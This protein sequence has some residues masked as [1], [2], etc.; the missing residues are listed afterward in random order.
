M[1]RSELSVSEQDRRT[2]DELRAQ[3]LHRAREFNRV[4]ILAALDRKSPEPVIMHVLNVGRTAIWRARAAYLQGGL[5]FVLHDA[6]RPGKP[7]R[8]ETDAEAPITTLGSSPPPPPP[9]AQRRTVELP[10]EAVRHCR[11]EEWGDVRAD[12]SLDELECGIEKLADHPGNG[13]KRE[14]VRDGYRVLSVGSHAVYHAV[15][16]DVVHIISLLNGR[17]DPERPLE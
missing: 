11:C 5:E 4:H 16:A 17:M 6:A 3:E 10:T 12:K 8:Y 7:K 14:P 9:G 15:T 2:V 13:M 1:H